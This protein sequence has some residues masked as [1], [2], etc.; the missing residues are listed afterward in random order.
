MARKAPSKKSATKVPAKTHQTRQRKEQQ[1]R[2][3]QRIR[4]LPTLPPTFRCWFCVGEK[5][6]EEQVLNSRTVP[7]CC[8]CHEHYSNAVRE[9]NVVVDAQPAAAIYSSAAAP[10]PSRLPSTTT[11]GKLAHGVNPSP[12]LRLAVVINQSEGLKKK[13]ILKLKVP[14]KSGAPPTRNE[15]QD[16]LRLAVVKNPSE[17]LKQKIRLKLTAPKKP[18]APTRNEGGQEEGHNEKKK[19]KLRLR[20]KNVRI[21]L[22]LPER[23]E[24]EEVEEEIFLRFP[25]PLSK[26]EIYGFE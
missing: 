5:R 2:L 25:N 22:S 17:R 16:L 18:V 6:L 3:R 19:L 15:R 8:N 14:K 26:N 24:E 20:E 21:F 4:N 1:L 7:I 12:P 13:I 9:R 11:V 23:G 10:P